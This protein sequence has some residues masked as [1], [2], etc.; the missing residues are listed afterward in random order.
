VGRGLSNSQ[1]TKGE[2]IM[3]SQEIVRS[4][5]E[6]HYMLDLSSG[7]QALLPGNPAGLIELTD[8]EML[9]VEGGITPFL[10]TISAAA[11]SMG[12]IAS[13]GAMATRHC[14]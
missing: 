10:I 7:D 11:A 14:E 13:L 12:F 3:T 5:K 2:I 9:G 1:L 6:E 8:E 4:W